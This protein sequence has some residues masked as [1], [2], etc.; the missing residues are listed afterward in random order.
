MQTLCEQMCK[1]IDVYD[2]LDTL[3]VATTWFKIR[4]E[5]LSVRGPGTAPPPPAPATSRKYEVH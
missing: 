4:L 2:D 1:L 5:C 3:E